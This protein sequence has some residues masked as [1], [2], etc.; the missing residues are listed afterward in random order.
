MGPP[1]PNESPVIAAIRN[2]RSIRHYK[3]EPVPD[4]MVD[5]VLESGLWAPSGKNNQPWRFAVIREER[6]KGSLASLTHYREIIQSAPV[7]IVVFLDHTL[8]YDRTKDIQAVGASIQNMLLAIHDLGLGG[9]WLGEIL[10]NKE[11]VGELLGVPKEW[12]LMAVIA[13]GY[14]SERGRTSGERASLQ[15]KLFLRV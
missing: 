4:E 7:C 6:L 2:R 12:E 9:V 15:E 5:Q 13:F 10:K 8:V 14:A 3:K 11:R 1:K